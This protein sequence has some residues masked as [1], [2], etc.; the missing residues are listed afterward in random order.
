MDAPLTSVYRWVFKI[1]AVLS[2]A[3]VEGSEVKH[4]QSKQTKC[5]FRRVSTHHELT[6]IPHTESQGGDKVVRASPVH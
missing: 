3:D 2:P 5:N 4:L 6:P 1:Q